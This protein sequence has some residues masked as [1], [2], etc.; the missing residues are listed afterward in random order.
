MQCD[1]IWNDMIG[2][3]QFDTILNLI[4]IIQCDI[5]RY[6]IYDFLCIVGCNTIWY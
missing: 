5:S 1:M 4:F 3:E 6:D 2:Y